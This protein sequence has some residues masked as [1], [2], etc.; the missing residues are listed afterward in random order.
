[1]D[2]RLT[3]VEPDTSKLAGKGQDYP[4]NSYEISRSGYPVARV[5]PGKSLLELDGQGQDYPLT[6]YPAHFYR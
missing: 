2:I 3:R 5:G 1:M 6:G 4:V